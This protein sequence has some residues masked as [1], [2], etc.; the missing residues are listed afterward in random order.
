LRIRFEPHGVEGS[1]EDDITVLESAKRLGV[2]L[3]SI[4][5]G[6]GTCGKCR[7]RVISYEGSLPKATPNEE[8]L[9]SE[10]ELNR[11]IRL[12]CLFKPKGDT[13]IG[14]P[15]W[16]GMS[17]Q[18][19]QI[20]GP[21]VHVPLKPL[22]GKIYLELPP[23]SLQD[24][25]A[26]DDRLLEG[27]MGVV[28]NGSVSISPYAR[29]RLSEALR[30]S[31]WRVTAVLWDRSEVID[32]ESND[33]TS[34]LYGA[35]VDL[36]S[37]KIA[38]YLMDLRTGKVVHTGS[39]VNPQREYGEDIMTRMTYA[40]RGRKEL[41][42]LHS[43]AVEALNRLTK[44][45]CSAQGISSRHVYEMVVV[46]NTAMHHFL[47][48]FTT[49]YV[50]LSPYVQAVR[51][52][53]SV[54]AKPLGVKI[55]PGGK[56]HTLPTIRSLVG[57]DNTAV[58]LSTKIL[59][60]E[61]PTLIL[62]IGTNTELDFGCRE[63]GVYATSTPSGPAFEGWATKWG[64]MATEGA[65]DRL[66]IEPYTLEV[67]YRTVGDK[68]PVGICG[69]GFVDALA[70]LMKCGLVGPRPGFLSEADTPRL[71]RTQRGLEF[72]LVSGKESGVGEDIVITQEDINELIKAKAAIHAAIMLLLDHVGVE[73]H[74]ISQ[75]LLAGA[76]GTYMDAES[77]RTIGLLPEL[78]L[79]RIVPIGNAAGTGAKMALMNKDERLKANE[80]SRR[81]SFLDLATH[82][83][84]I[85]EYKDSMYLP[86]KDL[87]KYPRTS[88]VLG[89]LAR[90]R[91]HIKSQSKR[92]RELT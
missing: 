32:V 56:L 33:T 13:T 48:G 22:V 83:R 15:L 7:V 90:Y 34:I 86:Y 88:E 76:F 57:A 84:F 53:L 41:R 11:S 74:N 58:C 87:S 72:V 35:A 50:S 70:E 2:D 18:R 16:S 54:E 68:P 92:S 39:I 26:D 59:E 85:K 29:S 20:E 91:A 52:P 46:G 82:P 81:V 19:L 51:R 42:K 78:D 17:A 38:Y 10:G 1:F 61:E 89:K 73:E 30:E 4:C 27:L 66:S 21:E 14:I 8:R 12:A 64:M 3:V 36:G 47:H 63:T 5:G 24:R 31:G 45:A 28:G 44:E 23:A 6:R 9:L 37:T 79:D 49:R 71:R 25:A 55:N 67:T 62:D 77:A 69:S 43:A 60:A 75:L 80:I 40:N 65:I